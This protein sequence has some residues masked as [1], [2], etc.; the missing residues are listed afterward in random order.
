MLDRRDCA[1]QIGVSVSRIS[2]V[3]LVLMFWAFPQALIMPQVRLIISSL[4][5][6]FDHAVIAIRS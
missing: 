4:R 1:L 3:V 6:R 5:V 2:L